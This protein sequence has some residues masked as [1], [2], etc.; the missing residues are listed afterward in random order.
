MC[1][2]GPRP[3]RE[4]SA[5]G[6]V[7]FRRPRNSSQPGTLRVTQRAS[8]LADNRCSMIRLRKQAKVMPQPPLTLEQALEVLERD[9]GLRPGQTELS[10]S[11]VQ[12]IVDDFSM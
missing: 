10:R 4:L 1:S 2:S 7:P 11:R 9:R 6:A 12:A 5:W 3:R 8:A